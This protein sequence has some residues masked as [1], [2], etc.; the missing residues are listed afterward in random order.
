MCQLNPDP[1]QRTTFIDELSSW[2]GDLAKLSDVASKIGDPH[3]R[4]ALCLGVGGVS[5]DR[6]ELRPD[7]AANWQP[8]LANWYRNKKDAGTHSATDW[9]VRQWQ[10]GLPEIA[11]SKLP[12]DGVDW[13]HVY[14]GLTMLRM[15]AGSFERQDEDDPT[16]STQTVNLTEFWLSD[17]EITVDLFQQFIDDDE[18]E[19]KHPGETPDNWQGAYKFAGVS[20]IDFPHHSV[21]R[22]SWSHA[23]M[24][25]NWLSRKV[26][27]D[28]CYKARGKFSFF[29][30]PVCACEKRGAHASLWNAR[31]GVC[32][33]DQ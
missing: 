10:L 8:L 27:C 18:Y 28:A 12:D 26:D 13:W 24:F 3:L 22:V 29:L 17:R 25:C 32:S 20:D 16:S 5:S 2:H 6:L 23:V 9:A 21:Q 33:A 7:A 4:S 11:P 15:R 19:K 31:R 1:I 14:S 30:T